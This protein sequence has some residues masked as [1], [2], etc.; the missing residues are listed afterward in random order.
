M[1]QK[2]EVCAILTVKR[3]CEM[4]PKGRKEIARWLRIQAAFI[5]KHSA[6]LGNGFVARY[7]AVKGVVGK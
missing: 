2:T 3:A 6:C 4:T 7:V 5:E 1:K